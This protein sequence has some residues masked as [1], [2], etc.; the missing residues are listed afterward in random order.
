M[1]LAIWHL[2]LPYHSAQGRGKERMTICQTTKMADIIV[3]QGVLLRQAADPKRVPDS[4]ALLGSIIHKFTVS[5]VIPYVPSPT[6]RRLAESSMLSRS[7]S[8]VW[9]FAN[10]AEGTSVSGPS[11]GCPL[12]KMLANIQEPRTTGFPPHSCYFKYLWPSTWISTGRHN[13][14]AGKAFTEQKKDIPKSE[15]SG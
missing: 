9:L 2:N 14:R 10:N 3:V 11:N 6:G 5:I 7:S 8:S 13:S 15:W 4:H 1:A 12:Q